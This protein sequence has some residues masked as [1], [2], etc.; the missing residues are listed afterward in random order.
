MIELAPFTLMLSELRMCY[1]HQ[2]DEKLWEST[3]R[4]YHQLLGRY[5]PQTLRLA[6]SRSWKAYPNGFPTAGNLDE[7]CRLAER[8]LQPPE[9][10]SQQRVEEPCDESKQRAQ[11]IVA[12]VLRKLDGKPPASGGKYAWEEC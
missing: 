11:R 6:M 3:A 10:L 8:E 5:S 12:D 2:G 7:L 9:P 1:P 4:K